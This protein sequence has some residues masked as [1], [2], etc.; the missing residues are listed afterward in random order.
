M[1]L[2]KCVTSDGKR[3]S[4]LCLIGKPVEIYIEVLQKNF[5]EIKFKTT[6]HTA[7]NKE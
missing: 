6:N 2:K 3:E 7:E 1:R 4:F 5:F